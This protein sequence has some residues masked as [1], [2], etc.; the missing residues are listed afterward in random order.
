MSRFEF[1]P[2]GLRRDVTPFDVFLR[3]RDVLRAGAALSVLGGIGGRALGADGPPDF[4]KPP[5]AY[6]ETVEIARNTS[7]PLP[8]DQPQKTI[9]EKE[10]GSHNNFYEFLPGRGGFVYP[11]TQA[12]DVRPWKVEISGACHKPRTFDLDD[13]NAMGLEERL[14]AF[15]CVERWAMNVPWV[16]L[17]LAKLLAK[18]DPTGNAKFV[19][20]VS[21]E[22]P[23]Q[24]PGLAKTA[25]E[26]PWPYHE[27]LRI[28]EATNPLAFVATGMYGHPLLKQNGAPVRI[29]LPW[30]YG[31]KGAKSVVSIELTERQPSTFWSVPPYSSEYGFLS[32]VNPNIPHPRW[33]QDR[34]YWLGTEPKEIFPTPI[35]NGYGKWVAHLYPDEP[36]TPQRPL[37]DGETAR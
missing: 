32:N 12:F 3:R 10:A 2:D 7:F 27:G 11:L 14:Y 1:R 17:P 15:R 9:A 24:M 37:R 8:S 26:Y 18:V 34:S 21:A 5:Y 30:K 16:G 31:Y 20:F 19:R 4:L 35:F 33:D 36:T 25:D 29:V 28:D 23:Q 13:L 22:R 6:P